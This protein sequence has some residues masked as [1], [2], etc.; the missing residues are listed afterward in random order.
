MDFLI[1]YDSH[2]PLF[3]VWFIFTYMLGYFVIFKNWNNKYRSEAASCLMSLAH[4]TPALVLSILSI[5]QFQ[6]S[7]AQLD[8]TSPNTALQNLVLEHSIAYF[9]MDLF[10][11]IVLIPSDVL[12]IA[13]HVASLYVLTTCRYL[14]DMGQ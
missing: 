8:F 11:Y 3:T 12:F 2:L 4:G 6:N 5:L 10:H 13:H 9:F 7:I 1:F 14:F